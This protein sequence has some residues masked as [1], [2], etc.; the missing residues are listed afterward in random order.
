MNRLNCLTTRTSVSC[1]RQPRQTDDEIDPGKYLSKTSKKIE[2][3]M[4]DI[5]VTKKG[6]R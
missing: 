3:R 5:F 1:C 6:D 4:H 2:H